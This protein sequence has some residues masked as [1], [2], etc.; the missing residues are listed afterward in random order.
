[1]SS[2]PWWAFPGNK[3]V[4]VDDSLGLSPVG[5]CNGDLGGLTKGI[6][7]TVHSVSSHYAGHPGIVVCEITRTPFE[8]GFHHARFRPL[9]SKDDE[10]EA[11]FYYGKNRHATAPRERE[12]A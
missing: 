1:M 12:R 5:V 10:I 3:V 4:C 7:Y 2:I 9:V 8:P 6:T 11:A